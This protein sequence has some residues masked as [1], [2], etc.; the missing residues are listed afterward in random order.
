[1]HNFSLC[2]ECWYMSRNH[3]QMESPKFQVTYS[4]RLF[5]LPCVWPGSDRL[6]VNTLRSLCHLIMA[7]NAKCVALELRLC[8]QG[9]GYKIHAKCVVLQL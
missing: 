5:K 3:K 6:T 7:N 9:K 1:M 8:K 2:E 4:S